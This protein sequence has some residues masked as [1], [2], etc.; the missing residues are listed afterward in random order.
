MHH[1]NSDL[2]V[3]VELLA[4]ASQHSY[5]YC[6]L[7]RRTYDDSTHYHLRLRS[8]LV[9]NINCNIYGEAWYFGSDYNTTNIEYEKS[10]VLISP[11]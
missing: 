3:E 1:C 2:E 4:V 10:P 7:S 6:P 5:T 11:A 9:F 8:S